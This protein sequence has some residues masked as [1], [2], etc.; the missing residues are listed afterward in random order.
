MWASLCTCQILLSWGC[1]AW[2]LPWTCVWEH[3]LEGM[4][5]LGSLWQDSSSQSQGWCCQTPAWRRT[6]TSCLTS[7]FCRILVD[8]DPGLSQM[9][10]F[11]PLPP[12]LLLWHYSQIR[13][14]VVCIDC[15]WKLTS[16]VRY[17]RLIYIEIYFTTEWCQYLDFEFV[18]CMCKYVILAI[19]IRT[20]SPYKGLFRFYQIGSAML[21]I[22]PTDF[23][24][25][26]LAPAKQIVTMTCQLS[27][28][29]G[30]GVF[31][32]PK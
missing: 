12:R 8:S 16:K 17:N 1:L 21:G 28:K 9:G 6:R 23:R 29:L 2:W 20:H 32:L 5:P 26:K 22:L 27:L 30:L 18:W 13:R 11:V 10:Y 19:H 24:I 25:S 15:V 31:V 4:W 14:G 7:C 3:S